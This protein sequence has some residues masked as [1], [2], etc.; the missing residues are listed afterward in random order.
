MFKQKNG[1]IIEIIPYKKEIFILLTFIIAIIPIVWYS[2]QEYMKYDT[3]KTNT[4]IVI[5]GWLVVGY[6]CLDIFKRKKY[7]STIVIKDCQIQ[8]VH[9]FL[10]KIDY[11]DYI[12]LFDID[13]VNIESNVKNNSLVSVNLTECA[14]VL[15]FNLKNK[16]KQSYNLSR[17]AIEV[18]YDDEYYSYVIELIKYFKTLCETNYKIDGNDIFALEEINKFLETGKYRK[19]INKLHIII[20][21]FIVMFCI[22]ILLGGF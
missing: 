2:L 10:F 22:I 15:T 14:T 4:M 3:I 1:L 19:K 21:L 7:I 12:S 5:A 6:T 18:R 9:R 17:K 20:F 11:I 8:V 16:M 13:S